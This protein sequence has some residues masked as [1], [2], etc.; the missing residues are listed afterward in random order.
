MFFRFISAPFQNIVLD[1]KART[2]HDDP[3]WPPVRPAV[4]VSTPASCGWNKTTCDYFFFK[5]KIKCIRSKWTLTLI[6]VRYVGSRYWILN[7]FE[8]LVPFFP[9]ASYFSYWI[10]NVL[11]CTG[12]NLTKCLSY[13]IH[14]KSKKGIVKTAES[15]RASA[16]QNP[17]LWLA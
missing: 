5:Y 9:L 17:V 2:E 6:F 16:P 15:L 4:P 3:G 11:L 12:W 14:S 8:N 10:E 13:F 7:L 1:L